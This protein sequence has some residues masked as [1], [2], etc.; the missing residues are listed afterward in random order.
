MNE[1]KRGDFWLFIVHIGFTGLLNETNQ[2]IFSVP[3]H[4]NFNP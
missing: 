2:H 3:I 4:T 1:Q